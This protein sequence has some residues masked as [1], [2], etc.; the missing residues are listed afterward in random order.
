M[1]IFTKNGYKRL[2]IIKDIFNAILFLIKDNM[3]IFKKKKC[4]IM[5]NYA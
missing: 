2:N 3:I 4:L 1:I 5:F